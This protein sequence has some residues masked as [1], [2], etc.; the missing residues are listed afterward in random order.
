MNMPAIDS[1]GGHVRL[2]LDIAYDGTEFAGWAAQSD[3]EKLA[4]S[5]L[6]YVRGKT[7][8]VGEARKKPDG[9]GGWIA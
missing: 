9:K 7:G 1:D 6:A 5:K 2:R 3:I 8:A 4:R